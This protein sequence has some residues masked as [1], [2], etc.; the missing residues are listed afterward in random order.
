MD[1]SVI[2]VSW[3]VADILRECLASLYTS[4]I[5]GRSMEVIVVDSAST[6]G[7]VAMV[8]D[9][10]P[11]VLLLPQAENVG[12]TRGNNIGLAAASGRLLLLLNPDTL[13]IDDAIGQLADYLDAHPDVGI[14]GPQT[15]NSDG[16]VQPSRWRFPTRA[17]A[18]FETSWMRGIAPR[19][20]LDRYQYA[21]FAPDATHAADW[22][23]GSCLLARRDVY[24][25]IGG[26]DTGYVMFYEELDWCKRAVDAGWTNAY[27]GAARIV[28]LGGASTA[29]IGAQKHIYYN[30]SK[31]RY[32]RKVYG[33][34]FAWL[35]RA[36]LLT[37]YGYQMALEWAKG[38][39]GS[40]RPLRR[41]RVSTYWQVLRS[42]LRVR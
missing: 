36:F 40:Q 35:L 20:M 17:L 19:G 6:D 37:I 4:G 2:I 34:V 24:D 32:F 28:H 1:I 13:I 22:M 41:E 33:R 30:E 3:N 5:G 15:L 27:L 21:D 25:Q 31:L 16:S 8:R 7:T 39:I 11:Q 26:L 10:F 29:Q 38:L 23:Q 42:G 12:Y 14:V 9:T 18:F